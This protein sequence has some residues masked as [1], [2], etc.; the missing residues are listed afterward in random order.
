MFYN[1]DFIKFCNQ[2]ILVF[3]SFIFIQMCIAF[4]IIVS[5]HRNF[6]FHENNKS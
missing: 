5:L 6:L 1:C 4:F 3:H 2:S